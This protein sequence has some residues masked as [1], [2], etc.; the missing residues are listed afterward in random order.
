M[1]LTFFS[2]IISQ[3]YIIWPLVYYR[4]KRIYKENGEKHNIANK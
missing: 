2:I 3:N 1:T 4:L